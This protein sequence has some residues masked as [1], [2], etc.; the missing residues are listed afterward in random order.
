VKTASE[1]ESAAAR[2]DTASN[3]QILRG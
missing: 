2:H 1:D 3:V